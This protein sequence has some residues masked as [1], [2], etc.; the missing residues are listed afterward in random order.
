MSH[1]SPTTEQI[2]TTY[3]PVFFVMQQRKANKAKAARTRI[4][5]QRPPLD[6]TMSANKTNQGKNTTAKSESFIIDKDMMGNKGTIAM[7][8]NNANL[9]DRGHPQ[10]LSLFNAKDMPRAAA[11]N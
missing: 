1:I 11:A 5:E 3:T 9:T 7:K 6:Q 4:S 2:A 8:R 10:T